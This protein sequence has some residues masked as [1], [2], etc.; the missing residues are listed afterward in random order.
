MGH[1]WFQAV[2]KKGIFFCQYF[3]RGEYKNI[4]LSA[5]REEFKHIFEAVAEFNPEV[6]GV[7]IS[8]GLDDLI[9]ISE[10]L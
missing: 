8:A 1:V 6:P 3:F 9:I 4:P 5:A 7:L 10:V 2:L